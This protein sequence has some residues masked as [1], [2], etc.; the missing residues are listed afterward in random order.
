MHHDF[1]HKMCGKRNVSFVGIM[2]LINSLTNAFDAL[3]TAKTG[4][5]AMEMFINDERKIS[6]LQQEFSRC[7]PFLKIEFFTVAHTKNQLSSLKDMV[8]KDRTLG[9]FRA[10]HNSGTIQLEE[11]KTVSEL[12][13][14]FDKN[15]G[16]NAQVFRKSGSLWIETSLTDKWTLALQNSEGYEISKG[17]GKSFSIFDNDINTTE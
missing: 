2:R 11:S 16:M 10:K 6:E 15:F 17:L 9:S 4:V 7:F 12:E 13:E 8:P 1:H 14:E 5:T 3:S